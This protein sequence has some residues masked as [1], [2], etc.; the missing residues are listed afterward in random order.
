VELRSV[1]AVLALAVAREARAQCLD[2]TPP[3]CT[4]DLVALDT[5]AG[6]AALRPDPRWAALRRRMGL[7][8]YSRRECAI[9]AT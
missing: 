8:P 5:D 4:I 6:L 7:A 3:P 9:L 2:G 1:A